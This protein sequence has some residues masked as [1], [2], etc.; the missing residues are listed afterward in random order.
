[1]AEKKIAEFKTYLLGIGCEKEYAE[2]RSRE[3]YEKT[4]KKCVH[5]VIGYPR[6]GETPDYKKIRGEYRNLFINKN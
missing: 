3:V 1:M 6:K 4:D 5:G 2:K